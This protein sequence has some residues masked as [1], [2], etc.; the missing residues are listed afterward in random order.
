MKFKTLFLRTIAVLFVFTIV[1]SC[2][3]DFE[4][5]GSNIVDNVNFKADSLTLPVT[6]YTQK[7]FDTLGVQTNGTPAGALGYYDDPVY[8]TTVASTLSQVILSTNNPSF[9]TNPVLDSVVL[10][11]PYF[12]TSNINSETGETEYTLDS[13]YGDAPI[14]LTGYRSNYFLSDNMPPDFEDRAVYYSNQLE[15]FEGI[16]GDELFSIN[17]FIPSSDPT[18]TDV[19]AAEDA[20]DQSPVKTF[21]APSLRLLLDKEY[22]TQAILSKSGD[23][24]LFNENNFKNY[25]RGLYF[26][27]EP[28]GDAGT[29]FL[30]NLS[31]SKI[32]LYYTYGEDSSRRQAS[33]DMSLYATTSTGALR[34]ISMF[35]LNNSFSPEI[36]ADLQDIDK[37]NGEENLYLKGGQGSMAVIDLFGPDDNNDGIPEQLETLRDSTWLIREANLIFHVNQDKISALGGQNYD[38]PERL[39]IYNLD[40]NQSLGDYTLESSSGVSGASGFTNHLGPLVRNTDGKGVSY[41]IRITE[42]IKSILSKDNDAPA[43]KLG[44]AIS[45]NVSV[46]STGAI[47]NA[48]DGNVPTRLPFSSILSEKGTILYGNQTTEDDKKL[49][50]KIYYTRASN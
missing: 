47:E 31:S 33:I 4:N 12:S 50:L 43:T 17:S 41:K 34:T 6:A 30:F 38:E 36:A 45:Q 2:Q 37:E 9:G 14:K 1:L 40:T 5:V 21:S 42:Y 23:N 46:I 7:F 27:A 49:E 3:N 44:V 8:G 22:F 28:L 20:E 48:T 32:T 26:K 16:E 11:L 24:V 10:S 15:T 35:G 29:Y 39:Y 19:P 18:E 25:F 13:V